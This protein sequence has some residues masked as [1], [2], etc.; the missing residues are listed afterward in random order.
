M[1]KIVPLQGYPVTRPFETMDEVNAY[2]ASEKLT[3]L[4]CGREYLSL[5]MHLLHGHG[6][7]AED[8][9]EQYSLPWNRGLIG[10]ALKE[11]Q[12][13]IMN[14]QREDGILPRQ[15]SPAHMKKLAKASRNRRPV[16]KPVRHAMRKHALDTHGRTEK[17]GA[18]DFEEYL[19]RVQSGRTVTEVGKDGDMPCREVFDAYKREHPDFGERF[20]HI[21]DNLPYPVQARGLRLG[22]RFKREV[23]TLRKAG[24]SWPEIASLL[25]V[26]ESTPRN[27]WH[28][29]KIKGKLD[30]YL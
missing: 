22:K 14:K 2:F 19:R 9:K 18:K 8:Y 26:N 12:A 30:E 21:W 11:K 17:W 3:C 23:V 25:D 1:K 5:H 6:V 15:P 7:H 27:A 16:Q 4:L 28:R 13:R 24:K 10:K 29:L 20:E